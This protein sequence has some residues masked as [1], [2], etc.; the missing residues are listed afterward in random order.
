MEMLNDDQVVYYVVRVNGANVSTPVTNKAVAE[1]TK[2]Q[3]P[4]ETQAL[5]E[6]VTVTGEG[7]EVLFG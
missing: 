5:A 2:S 4:P 7:K 3:L 1:M 6:V